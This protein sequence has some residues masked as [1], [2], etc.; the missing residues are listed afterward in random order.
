LYIWRMD[1]NLLLCHPRISAY[2]LGSALPPLYVR[3]E[4]SLPPN[5]EVTLC[6]LYLVFGQTS[7]NVSIT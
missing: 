2:F 4:Y 6:V 5:H 1:S 3:V 7:L